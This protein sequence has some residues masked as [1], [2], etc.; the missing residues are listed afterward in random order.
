M[1]ESSQ[2]VVSPFLQS[3]EDTMQH[4]VLFLR[5]VFSQGVGEVYRCCKLYQDSYINAVLLT[6]QD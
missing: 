3:G 2:L 5:Q 1:L 6:S 4:W